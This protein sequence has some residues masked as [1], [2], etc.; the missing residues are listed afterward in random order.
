MKLYELKLLIALLLCAPAEAFSQLK[1]WYGDIGSFEISDTLIRLNAAPETAV[2]SIFGASDAID[3]AQWQLTIGMGF[4]PSTSN[5]CRIYL[6]ANDSLLTAVTKAYYVEC[7][8][9]N[10]NI[11]LVKLADGSRTTLVEGVSARL[12]KTNNNF[13]I[14]V[15][16]SA[17]GAWQLFYS[18][19]VAATEQNEGS[20]VDSTLLQSRFFGIECVFTSTRSKLFS[21]S[22][23]SVSGTAFT[24]V[25]PPKLM[26]GEVKNSTTAVL[27][28]D[29]PILAKPVHFSINNGH[30]PQTVTLTNQTCTLFFAEPVFN[31]G[32]NLLQ[33]AGVTDRFEN[34]TEGTLTLQYQWFRVLSAAIDGNNAVVINT[35]K[36]LADKSIA[37]SAVRV[38][39]L[40]LA[41]DASYASQAHTYRFVSPVPFAAD[42]ELQLL[43]GPFKS[44]NDETS[45]LYHANLMYHPVVPFDVV[46]TE[47]MADPTPVVWLPDVEYVEIY[48]RS[49]VSLNLKGWKVTVNSGSVELPDVILQAD[50]YLCLSKVSVGT[51]SLVLDKFP[52]LPNDAAT[53]TI[54]DPTGK[55]TDGFDYNTDRFTEPFKAAGGWSLERIDVENL[56]HLNNWEPSVHPDGGTPGYENSISGN[57]AD[58]EAPRL[59]NIVAVS[60]REAA[61]YFSE[62]VD[63]PHGIFSTLN[64]TTVSEKK[65]KRAFN[66]RFENSMLP[67]SVYRLLLE[68]VNDVNGNAL[69]GQEY[70]FGMATQ[71]ETGDLL[72]NEIMFDPANDGVEY[73]EL[74]N[75]GKHIINSN[76]VYL[77]KCDENGRLA[78]LQPLSDEPY[79]LLPGSYLL[80]VADKAGAE[81]FGA[82]VPYPRRVFV[83]SSLSLPNDGGNIVVANR[84]G[85]VIDKACYS[86][87]YHSPALANTKGVS[88][89]KISPEMPSCAASSWTS[90]ASNSGFAT[91]GEPNAFARNSASKTGSDLSTPEYFTPDN[92]GVD[93]VCLISLRNISEATVTITVFDANGLKM[94]EL[95][96]N[97]LVNGSAVVAWDGRDSNGKPCSPGIY[98]LQI[99][100]NQTGKIVNQRRAVVLGRR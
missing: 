45:E 15:T 71:P 1:T 54:S 67:D 74:Y 86:P 5:Y 36:A 65:F 61:L 92:D 98:L 6:V 10:D 7:G 26:E 83:V 14:R 93:D 48:N 81:V 87:D 82:L 47:I 40:S 96:N 84:S 37:D 3:N 100:M 43:A 11:R 66:V 39:G 2:K 8:G 9:A 46:F 33:Y 56:S 32:D 59:L 51:N 29:E 55:V 99:T 23:L 50:S 31:D 72:I 73:I 70:W 53:L 58:T 24:D 20:A 97:S 88:L 35:N 78:V 42:R 91:P 77:T 25:L 60:P 22:N 90:T 19:G 85:R 49:L 94:V 38:N 16:R 63:M 41:F 75:A 21:F 62:F 12:K 30:T 64:A 69:L 34:K 27:R 80:L 52:S 95:Q 13:S 79:A 18:D 76:D 17:K 89:G 28:F 44:V 68:P 57:L 4:D